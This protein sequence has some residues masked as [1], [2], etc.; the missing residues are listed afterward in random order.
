MYAI[1]EFCQRKHASSHM[2]YN[3]H[4]QGRAESYL[5]ALSKY[6]DVLAKEFSC[7]IRECALT[8]GQ[9][10]LTIP[11]SCEQVAPFL[12]TDLHIHHLAYET[13]KELS[14]RTNVPYCTFDSIPCADN[15][16]DTI[17][18]LA[19]LPHCTNE[20][21]VQ[22]YKEAKRILKTGGGKLVLGDVLLDSD[23][24]R[25]LNVFVNEHNPMGHTGIFWSP[26]DA[27]LLE[28]VG[29]TVTHTIQEYT[30]DFPDVPSMYDFVR[31]LFFLH[32]LS[33]SDLHDGLA[34]YLHADFEKPSFR[35][36]LIYFTALSP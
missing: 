9:T 27:A 28:S 5:S 13:N 15:S 32:S 26:D 24:D 4:F 33:D 17:L 23:Q 19:T 36:K 6:P 16:V 11:S 29:F 1:V 3:L 30:W 12:P 2:N 34:K 18:S 8:H 21:R 14:D 25:W 10:F 35:W 31:R 7:A 22:F 20:E